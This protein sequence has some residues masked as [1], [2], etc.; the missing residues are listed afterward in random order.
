VTYLFA[1]YTAIWLGIVV[2]LLRL[3][4]RARELE[5]EVGTLKKRLGR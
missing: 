4:R 5:D 3:E 1:G 2:Y